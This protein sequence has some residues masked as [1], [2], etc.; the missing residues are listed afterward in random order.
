MAYFVVRGISKAVYLYYQDKDGKL[1]CL[2]HKLTKHLDK[3]D[4]AYR[5]GFLQ[6]FL[7][8]NGLEFPAHS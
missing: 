6:D 7:F 4:D 3:V 5:Q 8:N 1:K 2:K